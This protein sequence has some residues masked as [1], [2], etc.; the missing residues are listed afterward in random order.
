M[1]AIAKKN[2]WT[3]DDVKVAIKLS[4]GL[5]STKELS[6]KEYELLC[7]WFEEHAPPSAAEKKPDNELD[8]ALKE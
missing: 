8:K 6:Q 7:G 1:W 3:E 4:F 2:K 5:K